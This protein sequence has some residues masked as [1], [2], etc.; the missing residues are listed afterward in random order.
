MET[1][2]MY[3]SNGATHPSQ[4]VT[5]DGRYFIMEL[6]YYKQAPTKPYYNAYDIGTVPCRKVEEGHSTLES[7]LEALE[8][9]E[10]G[11]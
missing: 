7:I 10:Y 3:L 11:K 8:L 9:R 6:E 4:W 5:D 1:Y 2:N